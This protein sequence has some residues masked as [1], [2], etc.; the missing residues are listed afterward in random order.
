MKRDIES[1][2][3][4]SL[5]VNTFYERVQK[6]PELDRMFN[7]VAQLD[8]EAHLPK[9]Y[10][11]WESIIL[12]NPVYHGNPMKIHKVLD[13]KSPLSKEMFET[14]IGLFTQT[15]DDLFEGP[16]ADR[17]KSRAMSIATMIQMKTVY[18]K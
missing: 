15:V 16:N 17:A 10:N 14:W 5:M 8:W 11:F 2:E 12:H 3:D 6:D 1:R 7:G 13:E 18:K 9:M 4:I